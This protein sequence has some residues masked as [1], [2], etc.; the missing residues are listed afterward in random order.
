MITLFNEYKEKGKMQEALLVGRNMVNQDPQSV[1]KLE[2]Y[3]DLLFFLAEKLP[4]YEER[5][6]YIGQAGITLSFFAENADLNSE[7]IEKISE[8]DRRIQ[9]IGNNLLEEEKDKQREFVDSICAA[10]NKI[11]VELYQMKQKLEMVQSQEEFD[12]IL[13]DISVMDSKIVHDYLSEEQKSHYERLNKECTSCISD[14]MREL[15][16]R[17]NIAYNK[18]AVEAYD[19]AFKMFKSDE[20]KY[21]NQTELFQLVSST[22]FAYNAS[23]LFNETLIYYNHIYSYIFGKLNDDGKLAL[24]RFSIECE[25]KLR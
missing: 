2:L 6:Q 20:G 16:Y 11:I 5:K 21:R 13:L 8:Y 24:T 25:R 15:E 17:E 9:K 1:E 3:L 22:L 18:A 12:K 23:R 14:K 10:N 4:L 19:K 7:L